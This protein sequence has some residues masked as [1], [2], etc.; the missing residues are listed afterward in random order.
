MRSPAILIGAVIAVILVVT[1]VTMFGLSTVLD[2]DG[3]L[4][5][6]VEG[7]LDGS[8]VIGTVVCEDIGE[9][10]LEQVL[11]FTFELEHDGTT[12]GYESHLIVGSDG[13]PDPA[14]CVMTGERE[15]DGVS[16]QVWSSVSEPGF[17]YCFDGDRIVAIVITVDGYDCLALP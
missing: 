15:M 14:V 1:V 6:S 4:E 2:D 9:S 3:P 17:G 13:R 7:T 8:E 12:D 5:F 16:T 11:R 10:S